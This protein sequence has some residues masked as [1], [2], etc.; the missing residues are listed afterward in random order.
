MEK[1]CDLSLSWM[2]LR[3]QK[4]GF[5]GFLAGLAAPVPLQGWGRGRTGWY[6]VLGVMHF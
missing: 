5:N 4:A 1:G 2:C 3:E 6:S